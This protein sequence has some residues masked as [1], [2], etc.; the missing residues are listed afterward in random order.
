MIERAP[1][2]SLGSRGTWLATWNY[3]L[4]HFGKSLFWDT[5]EIL[6]AFFL[7]EVC[8]VPGEQMGF[9]LA[10]GLLCSAMIDVGVGALLRVRLSSLRYLV[11]VQFLGA[12]LS[13]ASILLLFSA[14]WAPISIRFPYAIFAS[15]MLRV[16]YALYDIPQSMLLTLGTSDSDG[17]TRLSSL[18]YVFSGAAGLVVALAL[19]WLVGAG[20]QIGRESRFLA[21]GAVMAII[22]LATAWPLAITFPHDSRIGSAPALKPA[23]QA[24][25][26]FA[27]SCDLAMLIAVMFLLAA[28]VSAF[29]KLQPYL[30]AYVLRSPHLGGA[31]IAAAAVGTV[32]SQ[33]LWSS[34]A[35]RRSRPA[36]LCLTIVAMILSCLGFAMV[37]EW[38]RWLSLPFAVFFG[39]AAGG[40]GM[41]LWAAFGDAASLSAR[42][43]E[44]L[45]Y[46]VFTASSKV[47]LAMAILALGRFLAVV[48]YRG[49]DHLDLLAAMTGPPIIGGLICLVLTVVWGR[50]AY[51]SPD[52]V[53]APL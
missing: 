50:W 46:G 3:G 44:G 24:R 41:V 6:L 11:R 30:A 48:D 49:R 28:S 42:G 19:P 47:G 34:W 33:P 40:M 2:A 29:S 39:A 15:V 38:Q 7:T 10:A 1:V 23:L 32:L 26:R 20:A 36:M 45:A 52:P 37:V 4:A 22:A 17:R 43:A 35:L 21:Y 14:A 12:G 16:A 18:R 8:A 27:P 25:L 51:R 13:A 5:S 31:I 9:V 53:S